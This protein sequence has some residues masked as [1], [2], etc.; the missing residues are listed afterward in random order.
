MN[1]E[2]KDTMKLALGIEYRGSDFYGWQVQPDLPT[3]QGVLEEALEDFV[4]VPVATI[5]A[6]RTD[7]GV[8]A[9]HQVV[10]IDSPVDRP[11]INWVRGLNAKLPQTVS[12]RWARPVPEDF[13][14]RFSARTRTY[15]YWIHNDPVRSP[16]L[17]QRTGWV[18]RDLDVER[19]RAGAAYLIGE[20]D[21][22]SFRAS[23]CQAKSPVRTL[24]ALDICRKGNLI[25]IRLKAN[26]F[27]HH[28][29]RNIVGALI[30]VGTG[31]EQPEWI[32]RVLKA[33][34]RGESAPTFSPYGLYLTGVTYE[35]AELPEVGQSPFGWDDETPVTGAR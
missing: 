26:A 1:K 28:M 23:E 13:S 29:V 16:V 31:R 2:H 3:V 6:G 11:M 21:F 5:C 19:M 17:Y 10:S 14:A 7:T 35:G 27:L 32:D 18:F 20:H 30:Y 34:S 24:Y 22:T 12:V 9:T 4:R 15:E 25:G 8:H 33:K